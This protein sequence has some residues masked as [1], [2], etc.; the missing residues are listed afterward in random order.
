MFV[1]PDRIGINSADSR[2]IMGRKFS[3]TPDDVLRRVRENPGI[4]AQEITGKL[5]TRIITRMAREGRLIR[6]RPK[7]GN[8]LTIWPKENNATTLQR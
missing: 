4:T 2:G 8:S 3:I 5:D 1:V 6:K 7:T